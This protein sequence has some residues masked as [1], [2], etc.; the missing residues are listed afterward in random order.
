MFGLGLAF[1]AIFLIVSLVGRL[2]PQSRYGQRPVHFAVDREISAALR[3]G[4][5][6]SQVQE[7]C[8]KR[9]WDCMDQGNRLLAEYRGAETGIIRTDILVTFEFDPAGKLTSFHSEDHYTGP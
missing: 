1:I 8:Q 9:N 4:T 7:Y 5:D 3:L 2:A 6:K